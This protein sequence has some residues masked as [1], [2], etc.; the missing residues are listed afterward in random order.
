MPGMEP[1]C[2][3][4]KA[5]MKHY[6]IMRKQQVATQILK[7]NGRVC[8]L[9]CIKQLSVTKYCNDDNHATM[10]TFANVAQRSICHTSMNLDAISRWFLQ[11]QPVQRHKSLTLIRKLTNHLYGTLQQT[12]QLLKQIHDNWVKSLKGMGQLRQASLGLWHS[13]WH[14]L[15]YCWTEWYRQVLTI[16]YEDLTPN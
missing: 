7:T 16:A 6:T 5:C 8:T 13:K 10:G 2:Q 12:P 15:C 4:C 14:R 11:S 3:A 9:T 1:G